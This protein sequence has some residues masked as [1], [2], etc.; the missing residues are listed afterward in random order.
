VATGHLVKENY[1]EKSFEQAQAILRTPGLFAQRPIIGLILIIIGLAAFAYLAANF[2]SNPALVALD[3]QV[4]ISLHNT[5]LQSS[6]YMIDLMTFG[7]YVGEH[8]IILIGLLLAIYYIHHHYWLEL[9]MIG[10]A[11]SGE[12][13]IWS[14]LS[15]Y[16]HRARPVFDTPIWHK[17]VVDGFPSGHTF[18]TVMCYS[19]LAYVLVRSFK[20]WLAKLLI[21]LSALVIILFVGYS[22]LFVG[23]HFLTDVLAGYGLGLAWS[24]FV[25]T[26]VELIFKK[27]NNAYVKEE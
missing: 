25:Y 4:S 1:K 13:F 15:Q 14:Q 27:R 17:M 18:S 19:F 9:W 3:T 10:L 7:Y 5:A 8:I 2:Q 20:S 21:I 26:L 24:A 11:W 12:G 22:R 6:Y 16:Y 23:D